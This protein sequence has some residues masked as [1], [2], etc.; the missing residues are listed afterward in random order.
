MKTRVKTKPTTEKQSHH[1]IEFNNLTIEQRI[2]F[3]IELD[4]KL[5]NKKQSI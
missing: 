5:T 2:N 1:T 3:F 4:K